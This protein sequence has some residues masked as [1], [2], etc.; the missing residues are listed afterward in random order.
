MHIDSRKA[1]ESKLFQRTRQMWLLKKN[2]GYRFNLFPRGHWWKH[3]IYKSMKWSIWFCINS[4]I[5]CD[6]TL[7]I[8]DHPTNKKK[9]AWNEVKIRNMDGWLIVHLVQYRVGTW[10]S[11]LGIN[12]ENLSP[13]NANF[14]IAKLISVSITKT[15]I[16]GVTIY[17]K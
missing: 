12:D 13:R 10:K 6:F 7:T 11:H 4:A 16:E 1:C 8:H 2:I 17:R 15:S 3:V 5:H 9:W 14:K